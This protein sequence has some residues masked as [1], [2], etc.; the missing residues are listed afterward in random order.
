MSLSLKIFL[1]ILLLNYSKQKGNN[2]FL[3]FFYKE[4][5]RDGEDLE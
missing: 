2:Y 5:E 1:L 3:I 4:I